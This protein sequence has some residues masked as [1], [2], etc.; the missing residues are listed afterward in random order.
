M[1][2]IKARFSDNKISNVYE[3]TIDAAIFTNIVPQD[4]F[5][6]ADSSDKFSHHFSI[7]F[8]PIPDTLGYIPIPIVIFIW[9]LDSCMKKIKTAVTRKDIISIIDKID[10]IMDR[11]KTSS[12]TWRI[13]R[14]F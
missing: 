3:F 9:E 2:T 1:I 11:I 10:T 12:G 14:A 8:E 13:K 7:T 6:F 4:I 5:G